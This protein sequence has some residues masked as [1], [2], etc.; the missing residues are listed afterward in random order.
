MARFHR[1]FADGQKHLVLRRQLVLQVPLLFQ[2]LQHHEILNPPQLSFPTPLSR[3]LCT[4]FC[5]AI[6]LTPRVKRT[7]VVSTI[8]PSCA[9]APSTSQGASALN[10]YVESMNFQGSR[11]MKLS[12]QNESTTA[13][14]PSV[15]EHLLYLF[16]LLI[17]NRLWATLDFYGLHICSFLLAALAPF[18]L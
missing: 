16:H 2:S 7:G 14:V 5:F 15:F 11:S 3:R 12:Q 9:N 1:P 10:C 17:A 18:Q 6:H 13:F 4:H 8:L